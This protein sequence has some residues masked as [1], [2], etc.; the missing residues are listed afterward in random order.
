MKNSSM[1]ADSEFYK[2]IGFVLASIHTGSSLNLWLSLAAKASESKKS[3]FFVFPGGKLDKVSGSEYLRNKIYSLANKKNLDGLISWS[4]SIGGAVSISE[5]DDFHKKFE[6]IPLVTIG[7]KIGEHPLV[8]FDAYKGMREL[9]EHFIRSHGARKIAFIRGPENHNSAEDRFRAF[10]DAMKERN[11]LNADNERLISNSYS[12]SDGEKAAMELYETRG[13]VPGR[14]FDALIAASDMMAYSVVEYFQKKGFRIPKDFI[15]GGFNN[16]VEGRIVSPELSTVNMPQSELGLEAYKMMDSI[17]NAKNGTFIKDKS[18]PAYPILRE[19][20]GCNSLKSWLSVSDTKFKQKTRQ[21]L[22][23]EIC[24]IFRR[25][26]DS[27]FTKS[28]IDPMFEALFDN[29]KSDFFNLLTKILEDYFEAEGELSSLFNAIYT[30]KNSNCLPEDYTEKIIRTINV[31][32]PQV[33]ERVAANKRHKSM[34]VSSTVSKLKNDLLYVH[35]SEDLIR[36]LKKHLKKIGIKTVAVVLYDSD[37]FSKYIG[38]FNILEDNEYEQN[39]RTKEIL[40]DSDL[41]LPEEYKSDTAKGVFV[42]QPLFI[43]NEPYGYFVAD[44]S[45]CDGLVYEDLRY[46]ISCALQ[47][48]FFFQKIESAKRSAEQAEFE[49]TE[50]FANV[51]IELCDPLKDLSAKVTQMENNVNEGLYDAEILSDQLVFLKS[52]IEAQLEKTET[53][54]DLTRSQVD[55]LPMDKKLFNIQQILPSRLVAT[56]N[57]DY[58]LLY[59]DSE[60]LKKAIDMILDSNAKNPEVFTKI[61]GVHLKFDSSKID[62]QKPNVLLA[63]KI[64][65]LQYGDII[66][67]DG[68]A[69]IILPWPNLSGLPPTKINPD[70]AKLISLSNKEENLF[71]VDVKS[72][73]DNNLN[74]L[75]ETVAFTWYPDES[76]IDELL[77]VYSLRRNEK[78]FRAPIICFSHNLIG[79][80]FLE[81]LEQKVKIQKSSSVLFVNTVHNRYGTWATD[82]NSVSIA[83]MDEFDAIL[84]EITP[85]L[86]VFENIEE[87]DIIKIRK[88]HKTVLVPII[89]L[90]DSVLSEEKVELLCT[91]PRII[92]CNRGAAESEQFNERIHNILSG[93]EILPPH[94][95]ALVKKAILYLNKNASQQIVRW[96]LADTV[97]VSED[98]LT[99]IFHKEIGL[100]LWEYLNR[101]RIYI[102][103]KMLLET[104]DTIY[105]IAEN[106]GFQDQAYFCRVF[107]K[108]YGVPPGKIRTKN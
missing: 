50:F 51:G 54:V 44:Y 41:L 49:K 64:I 65:L 6:D 102:A 31:L 29:S 22:K 15:V 61:D 42:V 87:A 104:N 14:D 94:T 20:C 103:T 73:A 105:E 77:K 89:V 93:D 4:S 95:G 97:H 39:I 10:K 28:K 12:W 83:S 26:V 78:L 74:E 66:R 19:S 80:T 85:S 13:L 5:L 91:H 86:I 17:L 7:H 56:I 98:Y 24:A 47:N 23:S 27:D 70:L 71:G 99:R 76:S 45:G 30:L 60:R 11:L 90:P 67:K 101:Y 55:D 1:G 96:K 36:I 34:T 107:K 75:T 3:S 82:S 100:S 57:E 63:E 32:I 48:I 21:Q 40:F 88:N 35:K 43:E 84:N 79:L 58:P 25:E 81:M 108:I 18:L 62:W 2:R 46:S 52:Q 69:E 38:G 59:G 37:E 72:F 106:S 8:D 33:Q 53:L 9:V 92:L 16:S 68:Y